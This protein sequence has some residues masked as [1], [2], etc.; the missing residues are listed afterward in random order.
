MRQW[1]GG[2]ALWIKGLGFLLLHH[3][4][5]DIGLITFSLKK[6][7]SVAQSFLRTYTDLHREGHQAVRSPP[8]QG[9]SCA[10]VPRERVSVSQG[11]FERGI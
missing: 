6:V 7:E 4:H 10:D 11:F 1:G 8:L 3:A 5:L 9:I 2:Q